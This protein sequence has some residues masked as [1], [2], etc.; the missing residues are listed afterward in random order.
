MS[1]TYAL[2]KSAGVPKASRGLSYLLVLAGAE[3]PEIEPID[4]EHFRTLIRTQFGSSISDS[5]APFV[6]E[7][8]PSGI[9]IEVHSRTPDEVLDWFRELAVREGLE[10][11]DPEVDL[12]SAQEDQACASR[13]RAAERQDQEFRWARELPELS[14]R[15]QQGDVKALVELGN[16]YSFGEGVKVDHQ[17]AYRCYR[18]AA[19]AGDA[20]GMINLAAAFRLGEGVGQDVEN[21][22]V[23]LE[24]AMN[25]DPLFASFA[26][27]E[28]Y[29]NA[30]G[31]FYDASKAI[32]YFTI[33]QS[34][35]H[36]DAP[37]ELRK[38]GALPPLPPDLAS[39]STHK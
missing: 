6:C 30:E 18:R 1:Q 39:R 9:A 27:G 28:I 36:Q 21:A 17:E 14:M 5:D 15:A 33:A 8:F 38:L 24:R 32:R 16:R 23:W 25:D 10:F 20:D 19:E 3:D 34:A 37:R 22:I 26:L 7:I 35:G 11:F 4:P 13:L 12:V 29:S 31:G 2:W